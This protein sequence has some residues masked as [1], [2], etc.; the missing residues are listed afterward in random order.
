MVIKRLSASDATTEISPYASLYQH[1]LICRV[2]IY[3]G[4]VFIFKG[5]LHLRLI[6]DYHHGDIVRLEFSADDF[7]YSAESAYNVVVPYG[8]HL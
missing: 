5:L 4:D 1:I 2:I 7:T 8:S 3:I 6:I